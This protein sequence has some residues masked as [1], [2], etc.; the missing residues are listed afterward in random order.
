MSFINALAMNDRKKHFTDLTDECQLCGKPDNETHRLLECFETNA[1]RQN[2]PD[3]L[4]FLPEHDVCYHHLPVEW[5]LP[6]WEFEWLYFQTRPKIQIDYEVLQEVQASSLPG[7]PILVFTDGSCNKQN[8][9]G[10]SI[11]S[12]ALVRHAN[13]AKIDKANIVSHFQKTKSIPGTFKVVGVGECSGAQ[14]IPRAE[15]QAVMA[16]AS[17]N[18]KF[19]IYTDSQ[20]V[21]DVAAKLMKLP[22]LVVFHKCKKL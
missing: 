13:C 8:K 9:T 12:A 14:T 3:L 5:E 4:A 11:A 16:I 10:K 6:N 2:Y 19:E 1:I 17:S 22:S 15:L 18:L 21:I 20:Y 7:T